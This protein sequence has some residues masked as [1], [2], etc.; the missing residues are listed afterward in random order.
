MSA[1]DRLAVEEAV[2][3]R[4]S[5]GAQEREDALCCPIDYDPRYLEVIP[6]EVLDRQARTMANMEQPPI[7]RRSQ[8]QRANDTA[9]PGLIGAHRQPR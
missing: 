2:R 5:A 7:A 4:Y 3:E 9:H 1:S 8:A 6:Q